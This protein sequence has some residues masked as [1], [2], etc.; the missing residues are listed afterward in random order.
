MHRGLPGINTRLVFV[1]WRPLGD[2]PL[3]WHWFR[4]SIFRL[5]QLTTLSCEEDH[6]LHHLGGSTQ[7]SSSASRD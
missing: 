7:F 3:S 5:V 4:L 2:Q 1:R 6:S